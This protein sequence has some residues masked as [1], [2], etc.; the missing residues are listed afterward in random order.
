MAKPI[1]KQHAIALR[2]SGQSI[3]DISKKLGVS[4]SSVSSWCES[5]KLTV[6]QKQTLR[7]RA[8]NAGHAGRIMGADMNRQKK[9]D[10]IVEQKNIASTM[11]G[12]ISKRDRLLLGIGLYWG[13]GV[14][15]DDS[16][17]SVSNSDPDVILFMYKW[18]QEQLG[19]TKDRFRPYIFISEIHR[20]RERV[21]VEY[22]VKLLDLPNEQFAKVVFLK[23]RP[24]KVYENN[25][26]YYGI[27]SLRVRRGT[28]LK[29]RT[30]GLIK[31]LRNMPA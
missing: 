21:I 3:G 1:Q 7:D 28:T 4:K 27:L 30:L 19:I 26:S 29:Y 9:L 23:G 31:C 11:L 18:F 12:S 8:I 17:Y 20:K 22:W 13:E 10:N 2:R 25:D 5:V 14:K 6:A 16:A 24:K 15:T